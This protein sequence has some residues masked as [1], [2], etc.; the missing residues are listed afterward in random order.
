MKHT[1]PISSV[2]AK[3]D[4]IATG[5]YDNRVI[6][7]DAKNHHPLAQGMHDHLVNHCEFSADGQWLV[8]ASSDYSA[9]I[10][11]LPSLRL[12]AVLSEHD[13]DVDMATFSPDGKF[14]ATCALDRAVRLFDLNGRCLQVFLGHTGNII[15][16]LWNPQGTRL[17]SSSVDGTVREWDIKKGRQHSCYDLDGVRTDTIVI[18][19]QGRIICGD[20]QGRI[21]IIDQGTVHY[22]KAHQAGIKK[23]VFSPKEQMLATLSY[24]RT[25]ALWHINSSVEM[26]EYQRTIMPDI[27][28]PRAAALHGNQLICATFGSRYAL[29]DWQS[30]QWQLDEIEVGRAINAITLQKQNIYTVGD[31]GQVY[32]NAKLY[33]SLGSLCNFL[34]ATEM[35]IYSGGQRGELFNVHTQQ[36]LYQH[37]SPLNC[38]A[39]FYQYDMPHLAVGTYTGEMLIFALQSDG[40][41]KLKTTLSIYENAIKSISVNDGQ[42]FSVCAST[43]VAW[44]DCESLALISKQYQ[45]HSKIINACCRIAG[46]GF[47]TVSRDL[48]LKIW[49]NQQ[50]ESYLSPHQHSI[51]CLGV[52]EDGQTLMTGSYGGT[53]A[54]FDL[55]SRQWIHFNRPTN[56]GISSICYDPINQHFLAASYDGQVYPIH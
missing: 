4:Y 51:K 28:W 12:R 18:D 11:E 26:T 22:Y 20:D 17:I 46:S 53:I 23:V 55:V 32:K 36:A 31:A 42:L 35:G 2:A 52:S 41:L 13:D 19:N 24:D 27:I 37:H 38:A 5:G 50:A 25:L 49:V 14:V 16:L 39:V 33:I 6:L 48:T 30:N 10:W 7:W 34:V 54:G 1:G 44:H 29:Y 15:S 43:H 40:N 47:A 56:A 45:V 3:G 21:A 9:R 8:S